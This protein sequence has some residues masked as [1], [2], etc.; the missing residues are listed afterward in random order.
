MTKTY[1]IAV[2]PGDFIGPEVVDASIDVLDVV[3]KNYGFKLEYR[4]LPFGGGALESHGHPL[5]EETK[6]VCADSDA[7]LMGSAGGPVGDHP[8]NKVPREK[9]VESGILGIR[10]HLGLYANLRPVKVFDGLEHL[11]PLK[12]EVAKGTDLLIFR[13]LTGG[14][15][16]GKPSFVEQDKGLSTMV[17]ERFEVERIARTAFETAKQRGGKVTNVDKA[18]VLDVSQ[19]WRDVVVGVHEAEFKDVTLEHLYVDNAAM[20]IARDP[21]Q[22]DTVV[23]GNLFGDILS[24]L[25][26]VIPG[27]LGLL[28]SASFGGSVGLFEAV[29][30]SAPDIAGKGVANPVGTMLSAALMLRHGLQENEAASA[31][32]AAVQ[33]ALFEDPTKDLGGSRGTAAFTEGVINTLFIPA[34]A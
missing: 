20:Q 21:K 14:I 26:A 3:A 1:N 24:D 4:R 32:E 29:H 19:F 6:E 28:P 2:L 9:R 15:Y 12:S 27:S 22:F 7:V 34:R 25:A 30:G 8:W 10:K 33:A 18:N 23:T 31:I 16:F 5:P 13:E 11:S 17:Y